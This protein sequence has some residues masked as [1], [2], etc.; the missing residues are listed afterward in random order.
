LHFLHVIQIYR[1]APSGAAT[2]FA[3]IGER[4]VKDGHRVTVLT[5]DAFDL[6]HF[7]VKGKRHFTELADEHNGVK[8]L[9]FPIKRRPGPPLLYPFLRRFMVEI[10]KLP[11]NKLSFL[12]K[13]ATLTPLLPTLTTF[14]EQNP[15][16]ADVALVQT[17][18]ITLDFML[19][20]TL[21]WAKKR[22]IPQICTPFIHLG[23]P[24]NQQIVRY[25]SMPHQLEILRQS[26]AVFVQTDLERNFL[27]KKGIASQKLHTIGVGVNPE[28]LVGGDANHF[29]ATYDIKGPIVLTLGVAAYDKGTIHTVQAMERLWAE[30]CQ[31]TWVQIGPLMEHFTQFYEKLPAESRQKTRLLGFVPDQIRQDALAAAD[32]LVLP[33]RTDSFGIVYL[34]AWCYGVPVIG[35]WAGGVPAVVTHGTNGLLVNFGDLAA[36][37]TTIKQ[38][39]TDQKLAQELGLAGQATVLRD[40]TWEHKYRQIKEIFANLLQQ[41]L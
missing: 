3:E 31:A 18:N 11:G 21:I 28:A 24:K 2:Y 12:Q 8:V 13:L 6:E 40:F 32:L 22:K 35:A 25:Y 23:E 29:R 20:P 27:H 16:L 9:R 10:G 33:S 41:P 14:L 19:L 38:L 39:L 34:E 37:A 30:N 15:D 36:L 5:T 1:P 7:W 17:T 4:L 26:A